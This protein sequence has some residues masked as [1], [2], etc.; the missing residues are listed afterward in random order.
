MSFEPNDMNTIHAGNYEEFFILYMDNE[1]NEEQVRMVDAFLAANPDLKAEFEILISTKLPVEE[2]CFDKKDLLA[3]NMKMTSVDEEL[4]LYIDNELPADK[5]NIVELE[6]ASNKD[7]QFQHQVLLQTKLDPSEEITYPNKKELYR[8]TERVISFKIWMRV[9]AAVVIIA[10]GSWFYFRDS[11]SVNP[12]PAQEFTANNSNQVQPKTSPAKKDVDVPQQVA[13]NSLANTIADNSSAAKEKKI[14]NVVSEKLREENKASQDVIAFSEPVVTKQESD[15]VKTTSIDY[16]PDT[17]LTR[18]V[19]TNLNKDF[20]NNTAVTFESSP[21]TINNPVV[22][23]E[24]TD[25]NDRKGSIKGFLRKATRM[26]EKRTGFD[27]TNENGELLIG[28]V[29]INLK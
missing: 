22:S 26:I 16:N 24:P 1:L 19:S 13:E 7:Y 9:A 8:Q 12:I 2:F 15:F 17:E 4:L 3:E 28:A 25:N 6:L 11:S 21:R 23:E 20:I 27:P 5:K 14:E 18:M 10:I 29:A